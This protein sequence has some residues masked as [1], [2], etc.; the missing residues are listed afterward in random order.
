VRTCTQVVLPM[1]HR[2]VLPMQND[3]VGVIDAGGERAAGMHTTTLGC[4]CMRCM[5]LRE[6]R[7]GCNAS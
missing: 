4:Q 5:Q 2:F 7:G 6:E 3:T 1:H